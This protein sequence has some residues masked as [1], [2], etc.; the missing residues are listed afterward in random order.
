MIACRD[1][2]TSVYTD[3]PETN[4][5]EANDKQKK[6]HVQAFEEAQALETKYLDSEEDD[7]GLEFIQATPIE[8]RL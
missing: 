3:C 5:E 1:L 7:L 8:R 6:R 4:N 2:L